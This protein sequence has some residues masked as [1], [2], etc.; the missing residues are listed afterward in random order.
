MSD[1]P[2]VLLAVGLTAASGAAGLSSPVGPM[3]VNG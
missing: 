1:V 2:L 3:P